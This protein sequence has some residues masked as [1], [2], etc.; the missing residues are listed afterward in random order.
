MSDDLIF[1]VL[2]ND[3]ALQDTTDGVA[4]FKSIGVQASAGRVILPASTAYFFEAQYLIT[5]TGTNSHTWAV[6][7]TL[8]SGVTISYAV[9]AHSATAVDALAAVNGIFQAATVSSAPTPVVTPASTSA[10]EHVVINISGVIRMS[11]QP[12]AII[13]RV[14]LSATTGG[15]ITVLAG[16]FFRATPIGNNTAR[17][18]GTWG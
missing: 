1:C 6:N 3:A 14:Q 9:R 12:A 11:E 16:S 15:T 13:P 10:T 5:N 4:V 2:A 8:G 17:S 18:F 7:F